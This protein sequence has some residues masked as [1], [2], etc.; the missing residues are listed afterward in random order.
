MNHFC[1]TNLVNVVLILEQTKCGEEPECRM[2]VYRDNSISGYYL[3]NVLNVKADDGKPASPKLR[4][5]D[6]AGPGP[7]HLVEYPGYHLQ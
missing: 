6:L 2:S 3:S 7:V 1:S 5:G 4:D